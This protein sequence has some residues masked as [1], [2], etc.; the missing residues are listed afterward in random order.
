M[1][2]FVT[3]TKQNHKM[4]TEFTVIRKKVVILTFAK[5]LGKEY[6][7]NNSGIPHQLFKLLPLKCGKFKCVIDLK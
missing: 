6:L 7:V 1:M 3:L 4:V 5:I 2:S